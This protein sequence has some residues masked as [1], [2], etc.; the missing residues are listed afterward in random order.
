MDRTSAAIEQLRQKH[1]TIKSRTL[2]YKKKLE[3]LQKQQPELF[4]E[5]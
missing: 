2:G 4:I 5:D 1:A 3:Q